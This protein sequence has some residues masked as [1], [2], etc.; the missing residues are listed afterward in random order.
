M[1]Y[2]W[3][4]HEILGDDLKVPKTPVI[5]GVPALDDPIFDFCKVAGAA[6]KLVKQIETD[7]LISQLIDLPMDALVERDAARFLRRVEPDPEPVNDATFVKH[8]LDLGHNRAERKAAIL[9]GSPRRKA[10]L[11]K[12]F[13]KHLGP[14]CA[15]DDSIDYGYCF[16]RLVASADK[17]ITDAVLE[18]AL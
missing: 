12:L 7:A 4:T 17:F 8:V 14:L 10:T 18:R 6:D 2:D 5:P 13:T 16:D 11:R 3:L 15:D 9:A 1:N